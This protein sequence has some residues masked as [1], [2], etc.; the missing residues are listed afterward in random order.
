MRNICTVLAVVL[1]AAC[2]PLQR[3]IAAGAAVVVAA[4]MIA[5]HQPRHQGFVQKCWAAWNGDLVCTT[6]NGPRVLP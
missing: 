2:T 5:Q 4:G 1:L 3:Q 6:P